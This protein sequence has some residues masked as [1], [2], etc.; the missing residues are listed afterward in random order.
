MGSSTMPKPVFTNKVSGRPSAVVRAH[1]GPRM[2]TTQKWENMVENGQRALG[3]GALAVLLTTPMANALTYQE[4]NSLTYEEVKGTGIANTCPQIVSKTAVTEFNIKPGKYEIS[5]M[6]IEPSSF[7]VKKEAEGGRKG[8]PEYEKTE[9][10]TRNTYSLDGIIG[11]MNVGGDGSVSFVEKD[12][13]DYAAVTVQLTDGE[14]VPFLFTVKAFDGKGDRSKF[15]GDFDVPSYRGASFLDPKGRGA[16]TGYDGIP[17]PSLTSG[18]QQAKQYAELVTK[19]GKP[20]FD[21]NNKTTTTLKGS[22]TF[23]VG[24]YDPATGEISGVFESLQPSDTD[25]GTKAAKEIKVEGV[26]YAQVPLI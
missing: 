12:G 15:S 25:L 4:L 17:I 26:W 3:A 23:I 22:A 21:P 11:D 19:E 8:P 16:T 5:K 13:L 14:R 10:T 9:L 2:H 24:Q 20:K 7:K 18:E 1:E 6:C